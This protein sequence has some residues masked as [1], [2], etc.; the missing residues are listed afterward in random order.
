MSLREIHPPRPYRQIVPFSGIDLQ[1]LLH[2][3]KSHNLD[4]EGIGDNCFRQ[5]DY[6][7]A[8]LKNADIGCQSVLIEH[9]YMDRDYMEDHSVF[10]SRNLR[11]YANWCKRLHFFSLPVKQLQKRLEDLLMHPESGGEEKRKQYLSRCEQF[12]TEAYLGFTTVRPLSG[13]P[14]GRTV[15][16]PYNRVAGDATTRLFPCTREYTVHVLGIS[17]VV[18]G[19]AFQQQDL[20]VSACATTALWSSLQM[21][22]SHEEIATATPAQITNLA[23]RYTLPFGRPMPSEGL[24]IEQM[25]LAVQAIGMSPSLVKAEDPQSTLGGIYAATL[26]GFAPV[27]ILQDEATSPTYHAVT[28]AGVKLKPTIPSNFQIGAPGSLVSEK[29]ARCKAIYIHDDRHGPYLR[30]DLNAGASKLQLRIDP[31]RNNKSAEMWTVT[32]MLVPVHPKI[33]LSFSGLRNISIALCLDINAFGLSA[34]KPPA[35]A[36]RK[37]TVDYRINK[38]FKYV[39]EITIGDEAINLKK[40]RQFHDKLILPRYLGIINLKANFFGEIDVLVDTTSTLSNLNF[41]GIISRGPGL[42]HDTLVKHLSHLC[43]CAFVL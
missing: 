31:E 2:L 9:P 10:Y 11:P 16:R 15:L 32:H 33:R 42:R 23:S 20:G 6:I 7:Q 37:V 25:C 12:S 19:L 13:C 3:K 36:D 40:L 18:N 41:V 43:Q 35:S 5:L 27:L 8:Y 22:K 29:A 21:V 30:A 28:V 38:N 17:L 14:V 24:S 4:I 34:K 39:E 26:S 1:Q